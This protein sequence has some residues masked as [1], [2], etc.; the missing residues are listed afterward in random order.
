MSLKGKTLFISGGSRGIGL[1][2]AL[3][4]A[5]DGANVTIAAKTAEPHPKLPGTIY[6]AAEEI[7]KAGGKALPALCDI[8]DEAQVADAVAKTVEKF[9]G[10]DICVNNASAISLT[11]T[12]ETDMKRY[13]LMHQ[14][15]TRGTF[16]VSKLCIPHLKT[17]R[18]SAHSQPGAAARH[19]GEMVQEPRRLHDGE[20]R[21][22]D[23]H[24]GHERGVRQ[25]RHRGQL[26]VAADC[27]RHGGG[28]QFARRRDRGV[29][30]P[31]AEILADAA[32]AIFNRPA[33]ETT[34]NF[35]ID[36]EVLRER[37][38]HRFFRLRAGC[39]GAACRRF[40]RAGRGVC[41]QRD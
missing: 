1:A 38:R 8:R 16:L 41:T 29:D 19:E 32:Y 40:L 6:T 35:F 3:R 17:G 5:R 26:A 22:V 31:L 11:G 18:Q 34:G 9:G 14:I 10:I 23:V 37:R 4:A 30:E 39:Q 21:H 25:G 15:N 2:I 28:A 12:L 20:V 27:D 7:E 33:R 36:E 24:A 13:D